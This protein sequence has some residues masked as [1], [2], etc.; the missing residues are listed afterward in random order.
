[1]DSNNFN[2]STAYLSNFTSPTYVYFDDSVG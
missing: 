1:M 2:D